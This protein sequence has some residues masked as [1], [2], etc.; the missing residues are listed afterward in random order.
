ML[1]V[2]PV[3]VFVLLILEALR[4]EG[5]QMIIISEQARC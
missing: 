3:T 2:G 1:G 5:M 4:G